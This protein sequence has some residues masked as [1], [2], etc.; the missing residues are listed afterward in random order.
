MTEDVISPI[1]RVAPPR[2]PPP[3][4]HTMITLIRQTWQLA[5]PYLPEI[6]HSFYNMLFALAPTARDVFPIGMQAAEGKHVRALGHLI[7]LVDRPEDLAPYLR[8]LGRDH[9]KFGTVDQHYEAVGT[10]LLAALKRH[11]GPAWTPEVERAWAEAYTIV[12][13]S[14]QEAAEADHHP[15]FW[16]ATVAEHRR[17]N[18]DVALIRVEPE[19]PIPYRAGQYVSVEVPQRPRLWR[20][21]SPA[22]APR[23][24][25]SLEFHV[26]AVDGGWVS[27]SLVG[28]TQSGDVW[29][30]GAP[31]GRLSV[32][33]ESGRDVLMVA[34]GTGLAPL[35]AILDDLA[36][37]GQNPTVT[38]FYGGR[39]MEDLYDL[40]Q[41]WTLAA[42]NP[43]LRVCPVV[44]D[45]AEEPG[46]EHGTLADA[47]TR[48][49]AWYDHDVLVAG[50]PDMIRAT[51]SRMLAAGTPLHA[52]RYDPFGFD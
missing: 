51:V 46:V 14:M 10:A 6:S 29:R 1:P 13:R 31:L 47:V 42:T 40:E 52:I 28:H 36:Q 24:D 17:L 35:R 20:Y 19:S 7:L 9:R 22:N 26:R 5:Q 39:T 45:A 3:A 16:K 38:L 43:W 37:W 44:E 23:P 15:P 18:W 12:A 25:C 48:W 11:L 27:R 41:L 49:G 33:R 4:V 50:S 21:L 2:E 8:Q 32:D 34:G 30:V